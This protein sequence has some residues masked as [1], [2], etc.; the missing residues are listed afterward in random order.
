MPSSFVLSAELID[1]AALIVEAV[2]EIAGVAPPLETMGAVPVTAVTLPKGV[3]CNAPVP[4]IY[5]EVVP[6]PLIAIVPEVVIGDPLTERAAGAVRATLVT[7]PDPPPPTPNVATV[8]FLVS[9][10]LISTI[11]NTSSEAGV[12]VSSL[13]AVILVFGILFF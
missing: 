8:I 10:P 4:S 7:V 5:S 12:T 6:A 1:P 3:V 2:I 9:L 11:A 13:R